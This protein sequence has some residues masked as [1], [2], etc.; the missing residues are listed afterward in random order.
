MLHCYG[1]NVLNFLTRALALVLITNGYC[2]A[3]ATPNKKLKINIEE[4]DSYFEYRDYT[5]ALNLYREFYK[6]DS[7]DY[8]LNY[9]M[10]VCTFNLR[11]IR[12][13]ALPYLERAAKGNNIESFYYLGK[14]YHLASRFDD[15]L[16]AYNYYRNYSGLKDFDNEDVDH[17]IANTYTAMEMIKKPVKVDIG[18]IGNV[19]NSKYPDYV[20]LISADESVLIFTS[21]REGS[22]GNLLDPNNDYYEDVYISHKENGN[23]IS[24]VNIGSNINTV[25]HDACVSLA[26]GGE[27]LIVYR[28]NKELTGGDLYMSSYNGKD[29]NPAEK[30]GPE[31]NTEKSWQ[32]SACISADDNTMYFSSDRKGGFGGKDLYKVVKLP[33]GNWSKATNLGPTVNT[34]YDD[35][36]PFI[37]PDGKTLYFSSKGHKNMGEYDVFKTVFQD[38]GS[39]SKPENLGYPINTVDDDIY[40][41]LSTNGKRGY[42]S[43]NR[44]EGYGE[45]DIYVINFPDESFD[46]TVIKGMIVSPGATSPGLSATITLKDISNDKLQGVYKTNSL[47]GKFLLIV[48]PGKKYNMFIEAAG[49]EN[50]STE[51]ST[52]QSEEETIEP[53]KLNKKYLNKVRY[54]LFICYTL[55]IIGSDCCAQDSQF[56]QF[57]AA[58]LYLN[59]AF[60][61]ANVC[62]RF[63]SNYRN[64]WP[65]VPKGFVTYLASFDHSIPS[66]S[67]GIGFLFTRDRA[68]SGELGTTSFSGLYSY[69]ALLTRK[70]AMRLGLEASY[71][72]HSINMNKLVFGDQISRGNAS[73]SVENIPTN[74]TTYFDFASGVLV[75][76]Y[77]AWFGF[78]A[79]HLSR[80][81]QTLVDGESILPM[82]FS[83]HG[84]IKIPLG[85]PRGFKKLNPKE[86]LSPA[87]NIK[88]QANYTQMDIGLYYTHSVLMIGVWYRGV[89]LQKPYL[90][91]VNTDAFAVLMGI[92]TGRFK[93]GYSYDLTVSKLV[94]NSGGAHEVSLAFQLCDVKKLK[95]KKKK[96]GLLIPCP[97]F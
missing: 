15:A 21:R 78:S 54:I 77:K 37:H 14:S 29:W 53:I 94:P 31:I 13:H 81:N 39:W 60:A 8:E 89:P 41:V 55:A 12:D 20:P 23:W 9:K 62:S 16:T 42:Y 50:F 72:N 1:K 66:L 57:Y 49:Y 30:L 87:I 64:Q 67:S 84:G 10:G 46:L 71:N 32:P 11:K 61:G 73:A 38:D 6:Y 91:Y 43:S 95:K 96:P 35:D 5:N 69:E 56:T 27:K 24:P 34:G 68:G 3:Q 80:P 79:H 4:A 48:S 74:V 45:T 63:C 90:G 59:P 51:L 47:T 26:A 19:I 44:Q 58:P 76:C 82:Q 2:N 97:K 92:T 25:S 85:G 40:F 86:S 65:S 7:T 88:R 17:L 36:A 83:F 22:T 52:H 70:W 93:T 18:N 28:T 33:N 75:Y